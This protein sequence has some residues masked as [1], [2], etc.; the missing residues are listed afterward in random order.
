MCYYLDYFLLCYLLFIEKR[1]KT[2]KYQMV[3]IPL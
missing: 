3:I 2:K 1:L